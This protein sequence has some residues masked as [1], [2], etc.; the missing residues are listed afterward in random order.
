MDID[1]KTYAQIAEMIHGDDSPVGIDAKKTHIYILYK[2]SQIEKQLEAMEKQQKSGMGWFV[3]SSAPFL[4]DQGIAAAFIKVNNINELI[5]T[6]LQKYLR[7]NTRK[8]YPLPQK[9]KLSQ[10]R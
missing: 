5:T 3:T 2:L 1:E 6:T 7:N 9:I 10:K 4:F 8:S